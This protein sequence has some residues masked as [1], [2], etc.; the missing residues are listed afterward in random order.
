MGKRS[1]RWGKR[2]ISMLLSMTM[3]ISTLGSTGATSKAAENQSTYTK[4]VTNAGEN[5]NLTE[6]GTLDW[7]HFKAGGIDTRKA[8][9]LDT[10]SYEPL[11]GVKQINEAGDCAL[12]YTWT[13]GSNVA[14]AT[15]VPVAAVFGAQNPGQGVIEE[16]VGFR[17]SLAPSQNG[18]VFSF[19]VGL[20]ESSAK[21]VIK[22]NDQVI[23][24]EYP[25]A[26]GSARIIKYT[27]D[28][29]AGD[30]ISVEVTLRL[31]VKL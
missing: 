6:E 21:V 27:V 10:I 3:V 1:G 13:D 12:S 23:G 30:V 18:R 14:S 17:L 25:T 2:L 7:I 15:A 4:R 29:M 19:P 24:E 8:A 31:P 9:P 20:W 16:G 11:P 26:G 28:V 5:M 22:A